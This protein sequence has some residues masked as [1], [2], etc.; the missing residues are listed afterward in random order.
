MAYNGAD[1][2]AI[3]C[4]II[5]QCYFESIFIHKGTPL[6]N[7]RMW[8]FEFSFPLNSLTDQFDSTINAAVGKAREW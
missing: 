6:A 4:V 2:I 3:S 1:I 5:R 7:K 8:G